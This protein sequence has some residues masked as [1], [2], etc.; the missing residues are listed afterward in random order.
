MKSRADSILLTA[1]LLVASTPLS[2]MAVNIKEPDWKVTLTTEVQ[3]GVL[4]FKGSKC[5]DP[6]KVFV[7]YVDNTD[8]SDKKPKAYEE[9]WYTKAGKPMGQEK[10]IRYGIRPSEQVQMEVK[11]KNKKKVEPEEYKA[12]A[13]AA[14]RFFVDCNVHKGAINT[15][16]VPSDSFEEIVQAMEEQGFA[17][18]EPKVGD[19]AELSSSKPFLLVHSSEKDGGADQSEYM[20]YQR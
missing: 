20:E 10:F 15:L 16:V 5:K 1:L 6:V 13:N 8:G 17:K 18:T 12:S 3:K 11:H 14:I 19:E 4:N 7:S 9:F 2:V